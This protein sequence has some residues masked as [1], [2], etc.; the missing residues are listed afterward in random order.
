MKK[1]KDFIA[2]T[3]YK[4]V[5]HVAELLGVPVSSVFH[6]VEALGTN[7]REEVYGYIKKEKE[8]LMGPKTDSV[9]IIEKAV[10]TF[11]IDCQIEMLVEECSEVILAVQKLKRK[12]HYQYYPVTPQELHSYENIH[13]ELAD[14]SI[15]LDQMKV[16]FSVEKIMAYRSEKLARLEQRIAEHGS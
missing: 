16:I 6:A 5:K 1:D 11:G 9:N 3:D 2:I 7:K 14:L 12:S 10:E 15:M 8:G 4:E 13:E